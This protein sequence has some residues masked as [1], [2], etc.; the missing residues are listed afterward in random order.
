MYVVVMKGIISR[1]D[2]QGAIS[3]LD[4]LVDRCHKM[5]GKTVEPACILIDLPLHPH[6]HACGSSHRTEEHASKEVSEARDGAGRNDNL[7]AVG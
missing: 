7:P 6:A 4:G 5:D 2:R 3:L 1:L